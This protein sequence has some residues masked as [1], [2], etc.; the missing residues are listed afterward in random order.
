MENFTP[1]IKEIKDS[2]KNHYS[3]PVRAFLLANKFIDLAKK[4]KSSVVFYG[5]K[6]QHPLLMDAP[7]EDILIIKIQSV[8]ETSFIGIEFYL[9]GWPVNGEI[10]IQ[11]IQVKN[12]LE[13]LKSIY[14]IK[15]I[16]D[17]FSANYPNFQE[18]LNEN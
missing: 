6:T 1:E 10:G 9:S 18:D 17:D 15:E 3:Y 8:L 2:K 11:K 12:D 14:G 7:S 16:S 13:D 4:N 5:Y